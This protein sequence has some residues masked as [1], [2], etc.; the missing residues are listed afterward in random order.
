[1]A[2][3][4]IRW[5]MSLD[6][7]GWRSAV[8]NVLGDFSALSGGAAAAAVGIAAYAAGVAFAA[9]ET[10][11]AGKAAV[12]FA[13]KVSDLATK[14]GLS[15]EALQQF[16]HA[17]SL[18]GV[19]MES[20]GTAVQKMQQHIV[21]SPESFKQLGLSI[22]HIK[23]LA[24]AQ[25]F[26]EIGRAIASIED[27]AQKT[28]AT[29]A[30]FGKSGQEAMKLLSMDMEQA[31]QRAR[32][33]GLVMGDST[34]EALDALGDSATE[35]ASTWEH[36]VMNF[37]GAIASTPELNTLIR[38]LAEGMGSLS[39]FIQ[40]NQDLIQDLTRM[41]IVPM[42]EEMRIWINA[43]RDVLT[44][45]SQMRNKVQEVKAA[46]TDSGFLAG[47]KALGSG[48]W[49]SGGGNSL[50]SKGSA[51]QGKPGPKWVDPSELAAMKRAAEEARKLQEALEK[52]QNAARVLGPS[53]AEL[54]AP[55]FKT[56]TAD[57]GNV[58]HNMVPK[59]LPKDMVIDL[60]K[61]QVKLPTVSIGTQLKATFQTAMAGLGGVILGAI[62][63]G[64]DVGKS[65][66][67]HLGGSLGNVLGEGLGK[68]IGGTLGKTLGSL[69]GPLGTIVGSFAGQLG[70]KLLGGL[71]GGGEA[72]KVN[73]MR[74]QFISAAGGL[75]ALRLKAHQAGMGL[76]QL[77]RVSK[78]KDFEAAVRDLNAAFD[79][80]AAAGVAV[81]EAMQRYGITV[82]EMGPLFAQ[83]Q[84]DEQV[85]QLIKDYEVLKAS[86][87]DMNA[88]TEKM[89]PAMNAYVQEALAAGVAIPE[90]MRAPL[91]A[92]LDMGLLTDAA[93]N[94][95]ESLEGLTWTETLT[96]GLSRA[97]D[98][99]EDLV[100]GIN[101]LL[102]IGPINI[103]VN[104]SGGGIPSGGGGHYEQGPSEQPEFAGGGVY[105]GPDGG[106]AKLHHGEGVFT[107][108]Q[109]AALG[110]GGAQEVTVKLE[111]NSPEFEKFVSARI[112]TGHIKA[113]A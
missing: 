88:V 51:N 69:G 8:N 109:M 3:R 49:T 36:L 29:I 84:L 25:Q 65:V 110:M 18:V 76:E 66:G 54:N 20:V 42:L 48:N 92:M 14:T 105:K 61:A 27:P 108:E 99:I 45:L 26:E 70:G 77:L 113:A 78:V 11:E 34:R 106:T 86:G 112:A 97:V 98:A 39:V 31:A 80:Q 64:G 21:K 74:D 2:G 33:L 28:A 55:S 43:L 22:E 101:R 79:Q 4:D 53:L 41:A 93:G 60:S 68:A 5:R 24:P 52:A 94:K 89:A 102:G 104:V 17:G 111:F 85:G 50:D 57:M 44:F 71:F 7:S 12:E 103:P 37:G 56:L 100:A 62:Q 73:D 15:G 19:E 46:I 1:M 38:E 10:Y 107:P 63:G 40:E 59:F 30:I 35:L 58:Y 23:S 96:E 72:K 67:A 16:G 13:G 6:S 95:M 81:N 91:Q 82:G 75:D 87:A 32:E 47:I 9:K 90:N 83:Q